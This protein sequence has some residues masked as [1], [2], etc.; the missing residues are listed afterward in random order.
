MAEPSFED[1][2]AFLPAYLSPEKKEA[3]FE[4]LRSYPANLEYYTRAG[5]A[6]EM[7][8]LLQGD[9]WQGFVAIK[10]ETLERKV[11]SGI[12]LS[13]SCDI[14]TRNRRDLPVDV[15][16]APLIKLSRY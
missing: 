10:F 16:F 5:D 8:E 12:I 4:Q 9:G 15:V 7:A 14:D 1:F 3:L 6:H 13:N 2:K 11:V